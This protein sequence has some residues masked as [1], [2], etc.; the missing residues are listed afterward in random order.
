[1]KNAENLLVLKL[2]GKKVKT[3]LLNK[4]KNNKKIKKV[5]KRELLPKMLN[6]KVSLTFSEAEMPVMMFLMIWKKKKLKNYKENVIWIWILL[7]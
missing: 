1:M 5:D 7:K 4:L 2:N 6:V 3:S